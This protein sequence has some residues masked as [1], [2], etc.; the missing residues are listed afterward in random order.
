MQRTEKNYFVLFSIATPKKEHAQLL[1]QLSAV[2]TEPAKLIW[3]E[4]STI[5][6]GAVS[7]L[8]AYKIHEHVVK[9]ISGIDNILIIEIGSYWST[10]SDTTLA[11][12]L[13]SHV[14]PVK[15]Y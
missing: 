13:K 1:P 15:A 2:C 7:E 14:G 12:W 10:L 5:A 9:G 4:K 11:G 8:S 3:N 6:F